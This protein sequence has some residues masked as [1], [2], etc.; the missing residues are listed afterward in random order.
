MVT[1]LLALIYLA[2]I[3][4]GLPDSLLGSA[5]PQMHLDLGAQLSMEGIISMLIS[6]GTVISSLFSEKIIYKFGTGMIS[7]VSTLLTAVALFGFSVSGNFYML[8][9]LAIPYG[10]GAG[11]IDAALNNYVALHFASRHMSWLHC[12]W[13]IGAAVGPYVM[14][15]AMSLG[16][17]WRGG[18][19]AI[20]VIQLVLTIVL[21]AALPLWKIN[22]EKNEES[23]TE[24]KEPKKLKEIFKIKGVA[25][26][27][28]AFFCYC[29]VEQTTGLWASSYFV[30]NR[31]LSNH[32]AASFVGL[33]YI[34]ITGGR[35]LSGFIADKFGDKKMI[36]LGICGILIGVVFLLIPANRLFSSYKMLK[37]IFPLIGL[38][39]VGFGCAPIYPSVIHATPDNFGKENSQAIIGIQMAFAYM[40]VIIMPALFGIISQYITIALFPIYIMLITLVMF[41]MS[42]KMNKLKSK[43]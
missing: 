29:A 32:T 36:R 27:L 16:K 19:L 34:G 7:A 38:G 3:S 41:I 39:F 12:F 24:K 22:Q 35:F 31:G 14:G 43:I 1:L 6:C 17:G 25:F 23:I 9:F 21:F 30:I 37:E 10:L 15:V 5:W 26:V 2:F 8:C 11:A 42:E 28:I 20:S 13:G 33:F 4:L 40:G 18:Y